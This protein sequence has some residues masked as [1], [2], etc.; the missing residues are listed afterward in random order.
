LYPAIQFRSWAAEP[1]GALAESSRR[2][3]EIAGGLREWLTA[4]A[5]DAGL[6]LIL[7]V[8]SKRAEADWQTALAQTFPQAARR[9]L[10]EFGFEPHSIQATW[11]ALLGILFIDQLPAS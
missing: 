4:L 5:A 1:A 11:T 10:A 7:A 9:S 8:E 6:D 2:A 3:S